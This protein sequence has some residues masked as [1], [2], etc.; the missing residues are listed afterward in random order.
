MGLIVYLFSV[1]IVAFCAIVVQGQA[2]IDCIQSFVQNGTTLLSDDPT[3]V[4][5]P[6]TLYAPCGPGWT[7]AHETLTVYAADCD[8]TQTRDEPRLTSVQPGERA[9]PVTS[10]CVSTT[11]VETLPG[12]VATP[13]PTK[14]VNES[15]STPVLVPPIVPTNST[16]PPGPS[17]LPPPIPPLD[18]KLDEPESAS[19]LSPPIVPTNSTQPPS[20]SQTDL[21]PPIPPRDTKLDEP[22]STPVLVPPIVHPSPSDLPPPFPPLDNKLDEPES[23]SVL[24]LPIVPTN[25]TQPPGPSQTDLPPPIPP[26]DAKL[27]EPESASV[28]SPPI[29]RTNSTQPPGP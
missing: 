18:A 26:L 6:T 25:S 16:Q 22:E 21:P 5:N 15:E 29:V 20:P 17:D 23:T 10:T 9:G 3:T 14:L 12:P 13:D 4:F 1:Q 19:V 28:L 8:Q 7:L 27:D 24:S 11:P 2:T